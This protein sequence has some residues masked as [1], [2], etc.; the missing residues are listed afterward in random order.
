MSY[1]TIRFSGW[2][3][4]TRTKGSYCSAQYSRIARRRGPDM[5][6]AAPAHSMLER[7]WHLLS[8]GA[9]CEGAN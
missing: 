6:A 1:R 3:A 7:A 8:T 9:L 2:T 4:A 5:A